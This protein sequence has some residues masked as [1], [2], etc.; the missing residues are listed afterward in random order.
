[1][2]IFALSFAV[3]LLAGMSLALHALLG[4]RAP[5]A[6][7]RHARQVGNFEL[8]CGRCFYADEDADAS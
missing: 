1:M 6:R 4:R 8:C 5:T 7:W 2:E 3:F